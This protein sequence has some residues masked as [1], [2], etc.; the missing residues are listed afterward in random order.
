MMMVKAIMIIMIV[1]RITMLM[2]MLLKRK[3]M[4]I[5]MMIK[6]LMI[7]MDNHRIDTKEMSTI[8]RAILINRNSNNNRYYS[9]SNS[10]Y[11]NNVNSINNS[12]NNKD[13]F[14]MLLKN[15]STEITKKRRRKKTLT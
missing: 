6:M 13:R 11:S 3:T 1:T 10:S 12:K 7:D 14:K 2:M 9:N 15:K 8:A 4:K 5:S